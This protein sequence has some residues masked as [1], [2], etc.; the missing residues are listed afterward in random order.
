ME[1][2]IS[3]LEVIISIVVVAATRFSTL[4]A[5][6]LEGELYVQENNAAPI[7]K[8]LL[9]VPFFLNYLT[10]SLSQQ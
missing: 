10:V 5:F 8:R 2:G 1:S 4:D 6:S 3:N 7:V 9:S